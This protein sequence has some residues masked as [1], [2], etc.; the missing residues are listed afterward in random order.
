MSHRLLSRAEADAEVGNSDWG[1]AALRAGQAV[2]QEFPGTVPRTSCMREF[3]MYMSFQANMA[4]LKELQQA[5][6]LKRLPKS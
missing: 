4:V 2:L 6:P 3:S 5:R 1:E